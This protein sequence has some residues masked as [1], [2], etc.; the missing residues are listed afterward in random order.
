MAFEDIRWLGVTRKG[1]LKALTIHHQKNMFSLRARFQQLSASQ[2]RTVQETL[3]EDALERWRAFCAAKGRVSYVESVCG[4]RQAIDLTLPTDAFRSVQENRDIAEVERRY[5]EPICALQDE[6][7][8]IPK[9]AIFAYY[10][11]YNLFNRYIKVEDIDDWLIVNQALSA[12]ADESRWR[13]MLDAA[14]EKA[15]S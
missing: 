13:A 11:I 8:V 9:P 3:C 7:L 5:S 6:D 4:T 2:K 12:E 1:D 14:I 15:T 10:A